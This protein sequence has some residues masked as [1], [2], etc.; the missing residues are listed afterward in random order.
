M[1]TW[2]LKQPYRWAYM[3]NYTT[4]E[5]CYTVSYISCYG[6]NS[7]IYSITSVHRRSGDGLCVCA[8]DCSGA[9]IFGGPIVYMYIQC[10]K[11]VFPYTHQMCLPCCI[12]ILNS[13]AWVVFSRYMYFVWQLMSLFLLV[14]MYIYIHVYIHSPT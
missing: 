1:C 14:Q 9:A 12:L 13:W 2:P 4:M 3:Y 7:I 5:D 6:S 8:H 11:M 10:S